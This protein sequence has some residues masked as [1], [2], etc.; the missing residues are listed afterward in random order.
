MAYNAQ[1]FW[2]PENDDVVKGT[3][4]LMAGDSPLIKQ[5]RSQGM[6][7][8]N[9]RGLLNSSMAA[10]AAQGAAYAAAIPLASQNS[11]QTHTK[12]MQGQERL[13][14]LERQNVDNTAQMDRLTT[15][16]KAELDRLGA[17]A[18]YDLTRQN[19]QNQADMDRLN[20][21][22]EL[23][24]ATQQR[25]ITANMAQLQE[26]GRLEAQRQDAQNLANLEL[27]RQGGNI[28][29]AKINTQADRAMEELKTS[30]ASQDRERATAAAT[31]MLNSQDSLLAAIMGNPDIDAA[32]RERMLAD[33]QARRQIA[34]DVVGQLYDVELTWGQN[35]LQQANTQQQQ[36]TNPTQFPILG[37]TYASRGGLLQ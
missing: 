14:L 11:S 19:A 26:S 27:Q 15:N 9:R 21:S 12:N 1:G 6:A 37:G 10:G 22:G 13:G 31:S 29:I 16:N 20:R 8:G 35:G 17:A 24:A 5:A 3:T 18:G 33:N 34:L 4:D 30:L 23:D 7:A 32:T 2:E 28:D 25:T 36:Q